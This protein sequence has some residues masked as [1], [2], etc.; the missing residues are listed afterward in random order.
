MTQ[1]LDPEKLINLYCKGYFPMADS[2]TSS[3]IKFYKPNNRFIIPIKEFHVPKRLLIDY[4]KK[5]YEYKIDAEFK[6]VIFQCSLPRKN[7]EDTWINNTIINSYINLHKL[8]IAHSIE[9]WSKKKLI[10]GLYGVHLGK[11]FFGESMF[12]TISNASKFCLL[13]LIAILIK[14]NFLLLDSQFYNKHLTQFGA[15]EI[16]DKE[17]QKKLNVSLQNRAEFNNKISY[18]ESIEILQSLTQIS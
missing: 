5:G 4:K 1:V 6:N 12:S 15:Y 17:Y 8:D 9:C 13:Y 16:S 18:E 14:N 3:K 2:A 10:G 11:C 7:H